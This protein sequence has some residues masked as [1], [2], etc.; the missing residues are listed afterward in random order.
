LATSFFTAYLR[1]GVSLEVASAEQMT[2]SEFS[3]TLTNP[4]ILA[5]M[6]MP[7]MKGNLVMQITAQLGYAIIDRIL[8]GPGL[9]MKRLRDFSEIEIILLE[10]VINQAL[11][12][13]PEAFENIGSYKPKI[14]KIETNAQF[15]QI[16][17]P[18]EMCALVTIQMKVGNVEGF[19]NFCFPHITIESI[20]SKLNTRYRY[21]GA[22]V[23]RD[24]IYGE[25]IERELDKAK[26]TVSAVIG[27]T[28]LSVNNIIEL[29]KGDVIPLDSFINSDLQIMVGPLLKFHAKPG[30]KRGR[31]AVQITSIIEREEG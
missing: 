27:R 3:N 24:P 19:M 13:L 6:Q 29:Q 16:I 4:V 10:R 15:A 28:R 11:T 25:K 17:Q 20:M 1:T 7:P 30:I 8:G 31:N 23:V 26:V 22:N 5:I 2:Y 21:A 12:S 14:E 18:G 9:S